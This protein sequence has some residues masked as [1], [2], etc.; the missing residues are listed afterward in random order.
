MGAAHRVTVLPAH[1]KNM[2]RAE[3]DEGSTDLGYADPRRPLGGGQDGGAI[4]QEVARERGRMNGRWRG[5]M[6]REGRKEKFWW[7]Q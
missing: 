1:T 7:F 2:L 3:E 4:E 6:E 5:G